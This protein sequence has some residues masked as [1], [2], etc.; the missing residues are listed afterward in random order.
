MLL[1]LAIQLVVLISPNIIVAASFDDFNNEK[2]DSNKWAVQEFVRVVEDEMLSM[3]GSHRTDKNE[4]NQVETLFKNPELITKLQATITVGAYQL[5]PDITTEWNQMVAAELSGSY[6][7]SANG[8][9]DA[10]I[11]II[12]TNG[13]EGLKAWCYASS[14]DDVFEVNH[15]FTMSIETGH[16]YILAIEYKEADQKFT[17]SIEDGNNPATKENKDLDV[18]STPSSGRPGREKK[19]L[20][21][22]YTIDGETDGTFDAEISLAAIIDDIETQEGPYDD[23]TSNTLSSSKW[24]SVESVRRITDN[25]LELSQRSEGI[26]FQTTRILTADTVRSTDYYQVSI[27]VDS[28]SYR[29]G[30]TT[31]VNTG[32]SGFFYND[33][34]E[35]GNQNMV[36]DHLAMVAFRLSP[37]NS[38]EAEATIFRCGNA[39]CSDAV[40]NRVWS[41]E[42]TTKPLFNTQQTVSIKNTGNSLIFD[43]EGEQIVHS[44]TETFSPFSSIRMLETLVWSNGSED[45][46]MVV[47][48]DN[49][50]FEEQTSPWSL[51]LP[52]I[53]TSPKSN[54]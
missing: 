24:N 40:A 45:G 1:F 22:W 11:S 20:R 29:N 19:A 16:P 5:D 33:I 21:V 49:V 8:D 25:S 18:S 42:F 46:N 38:L 9:V 23:F 35:G 51:F 39:D 12:D 26:P 27:R 37:E 32:M 13:G 34:A 54:E 2:I 47:F 30:A 53:L 28:A 14:Q 10:G 31:A 15:K 48:F 41:Q 36:G 3:A 7:G 50:I 6:Y 43:M 17:C 44:I 52:A 4:H